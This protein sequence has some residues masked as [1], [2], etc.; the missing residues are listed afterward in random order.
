M[1]AYSQDLR[2]RVLRAIERGDRPTNIA[3]RFEVSREWV[4]QVKARFKKEGLRHSFQIGGHRKSRLAPMEDQIRGWI[5]E[6]ADITLS[7]L[8]DRLSK[9]GIEIKIPALWHQL[10]KWGLSFKKNSTR[11]RARAGRRPGGPARMDSKPTR[12]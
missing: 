6:E 8:V 5:K 2:E 4:Y 7:E 12:A 11:Q 10:D 1:H 3:A 9:Q